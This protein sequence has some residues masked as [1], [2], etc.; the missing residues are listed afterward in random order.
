M[1]K[2]RILAIYNKITQIAQKGTYSFIE[3]Y[4]YIDDIINNSEYIFL[5]DVFS[6][7]YATDIRLYRTITLLKQQTWPI[8]LGDTDTTFMYRLKSFYDSN[9]VYQ[10]GQG[11]YDSSDNE[12]L[13]KFVELDRIDTVNFLGV[14][15]SIPPH[16]DFYR[17]TDLSVILDQPKAIIL[18]VQIGAF[19][20]DLKV[21]LNDPNMLLLDKYK[22]GV[23]LLI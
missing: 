10:I 17:N 5:Q 23:S 15:Y 8:V 9:G 1:R 18:Q 14:T 22:L 2:K 12:L 3:Y 11:I 16:Y 4:N 6:I 19:D 21:L 7:Y 13:G 20:N